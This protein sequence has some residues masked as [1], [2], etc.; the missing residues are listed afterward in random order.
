MSSI[1]DRE[2]HR[3][4]RLES[5]SKPTTPPS[6]RRHGL[7]RLGLAVSQRIA[8]EGM[9]DL[10]TVE[11]EL[12]KGSDFALVICRPRAWGAS[13]KCRRGEQG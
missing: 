5:S 4:R 6:W 13:K 12:G 1:P 2:S 11:S 9:V 10:I 3:K 8:T 7:C